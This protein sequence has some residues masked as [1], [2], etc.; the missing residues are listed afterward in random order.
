MI[1]L[2]EAA[3]Q[4]IKE[5]MKKENL[6]G[7]FLRVGVKGGGCAGLEYDLEL[8]KSSGENDMVFENGDVKVFCSPKEYLHLCG[9][10]IDYVSSMLSSGFKFSNPNASKSCGCGTSFSTG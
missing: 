2:T 3:Q 6:E 8:K 7:W 1:K 9:V 10:E 5:T 4:A